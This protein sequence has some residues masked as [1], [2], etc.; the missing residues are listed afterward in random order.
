MIE[1]KEIVKSYGQNRVLTDACLKLE[2][3]AIV[4]LQGRNG[5]GKT[6]LINIIANRIK[7]DNGEFWVDSEKIDFNSYKY[8]QKTAFYVGAE[9]LIENLTL[10]EYLSFAASLYSIPKIEFETRVDELLK[11]FELPKKQL[12]R[13][14]SK[15]MKTKAAL[16]ATFLQDAKYLILDEPFENLDKETV[17]NL[18]NYFLHLAQKKKGLLITT[19]LSLDMESFPHARVVLAN[20]RTTDIF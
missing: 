17:A 11:F 18:Q 5:C 9:T 14:F 6:T 3:G 15:S 16:C 4:V 19:H 8:K 20:G 2:P 1:L 10:L 13:N 12:I 7:M